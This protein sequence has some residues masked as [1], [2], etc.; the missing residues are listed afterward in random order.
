MCAV[1]VYIYAL[2]AFCIEIA[3]KVASL[4]YDKAALAC[5]CGKVGKGGSKKSGAYYKV[6]VFTGVVHIQGQNTDIKK[7]W[8]LTVAIP[9]S[10]AFALPSI[11]ERQREA[12]ADTRAH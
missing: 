7:A 9:R 3:A 6:V 12:H 8:N 5:S 4:V 10:E 1:L 2:N 11:Q